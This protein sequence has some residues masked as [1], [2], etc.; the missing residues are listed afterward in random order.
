MT[1]QYSSQ[2]YQYYL[3]IENFEKASEL[4]AKDDQSRLVKIQQLVNLLTNEPRQSDILNQFSLT[5]DLIEGILAELKRRGKENLNTIQ[6]KLRHK[7]FT[8][9]QLFKFDFVTYL[10]RFL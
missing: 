7:S 10:Y 4:L 2:V 8:T 3:N 5:S 6:S 1:N 9:E